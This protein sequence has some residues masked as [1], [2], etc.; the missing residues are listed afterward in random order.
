MHARCRGM[1]TDDYD[2]AFTDALAWDDRRPM[3]FERARTQ[4]A[5]AGGCAASAGADARVRLRAAL[6]G[7][8]RL[9][10]VPWAVQARDELRAAGGRL[11][12]APAGDPA[13]L[14]AQEVHVATT[15]AR[16]GSTRDI[17]A[18]LCLAPKTV[19]FHLSQ[20]YRKLGVRTRARMI[21]VL[22]EAGVAQSADPCD[23]G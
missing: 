15:A 13:T 19:E 22:A 7:F 5:S 21:V 17:A 6:E 11:R 18:E 10:A 4:L 23:G 2:A 20:I 12:T 3:P 9:G 8:D 14:T 16:G 1:L